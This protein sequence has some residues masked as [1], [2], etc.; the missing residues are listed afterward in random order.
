MS[1][2]NQI[3]N[4]LKEIDG[5]AF[6]KLSDTYILKK[7]YQ[8]INPIGSVLGADKV[9]TGTPDSYARQE[10]GKLIFAE[11]T[12]D[13]KDIYKKLRGDLEKC[14]DVKKTGIPLSEI[15]EVVFCHNSQLS[16]SGE[17]DLYNTCKA[18]GIKIQIF[19]LEG[20]SFDF[21]QKYPA[22]AHDFLGIDV[23]TG[24]ILEPKEFVENIGKNQISTPLDTEF[25]FREEETQKILESM[26]N[27]N[28]VILSGAAGVGK[29]RLALEVIDQF[30]SRHDDYGLW[31]VYNKGPD[32]FEDI[33]SYFSQ[34]GSFLLLVDDANRITQ[35]DYIVD[36]IQN[37]REDQ[38]IKVIATVRDYA[39]DK[40][41]HSAKALGNVSEFEIKP[42]TKDEIKEFIEKQYE[43]K[44]T[45][46]LDRISE[47]A[48]GNPRL[49]VMAAILAVQENTLESIRDVS[50]LYDSYFSS[51][52]NDLEHLQDKNILK[53]AGIISFFRIVDRSNDKV[54]QMIQNV[55]EISSSDFWKAVEYL[56]GAEIVDIY[57]NEVVKISDQVLS[58]YLFYLCFL[59]GNKT[60][61]S[62]LL[63][64]FFPSQIDRVRDAI[65]P[66]FNSFDFDR[67]AKKISPAVRKKWSECRDNAND[68]EL[69]G[70]IKTFWFLLQTDVLVY[71]R[72]NMGAMNEQCTDVDD[73]RFDSN[74]VTFSDHPLLEILGFFKQADEEGTF[75]SALALCFEYVRKRPNSAPQFINI[76]V[77]KFGFD[78][79]SH[80]NEYLLQKIVIQS[81]WEM[82]EGGS[83][84][85]FSKLFLEVASKYL[86]TRYDSHEASKREVTIHKFVLLEIEPINEI[87][88]IIWNGIFTIHKESSLRDHALSVLKNYCDSGYYLSQSEI[89]KT[90]AQY[91]VPFLNENLS[92]NDFSD[93]LLVQKY[94]KLLKGRNIDISHDV[95]DEF[96]SGSYELY[97]I[98]SFDYSDVE[99]DNIHDFDEIKKDRTKEYLKGFDFDK[100][101]EFVLLAREILSSLENNHDAYRIKSS[102][103][104][105][106]SYLDEVDESLYKEIMKDYITSGDPLDIQHP[107]IILNKLIKAFGSSSTKTLLDDAEFGTKARWLFDYYRCL[108]DGDIDEKVA[109]GLIELYKDSEIKDLPYDY[110]YLLRFVESRETVV[111][112]VV[113]IIVSKLDEASSGLSCFD[114]IFNPHSEVN[115]RILELFE[116]NFNLLKRVYLLHCKTKDHADYDGS[117]LRRILSVDQDFILEII[118]RIYTD[119]EWPDRYS[120]SRDYSF[121][122][123]H[124]NCE[125]I[126]MSATREVLKREVEK[127]YFSENYLERLF[128]IHDNKECPQEVVNKQDDFLGDV[129]SENSLD[130]DF[131]RFIF[132]VIS[133]FS[134]ERRRK[135]IALFLNKN[136]NY[137]DFEKLSFEPSHWS[138]SGSKVPM[139]QAKADFWGM[140]LPLCDSVE[141][142]D[143]KLF[144][145][146][147]IQSYREAVEREKKSNFMDEFD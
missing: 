103:P 3:Q 129:I 136:K 17:Q 10:N 118:D 84:E 105:V 66:C 13:Q 2:L 18:N 144:I 47:I 106:F 143:H 88:K 4:A 11:Y 44:N 7:G 131:M 134:A 34:S 130:S 23:D 67:M 68:N 24:Q 73:I 109:A 132:N 48:G 101:K 116:G 138:C 39:R 8:N 12:T 86:P 112:E 110:D 31:V 46:Y 1:K 43:I 79:H 97:K 114:L 36:L 108:P 62:L 42:L 115:K 53:V 35:F 20:I 51:I 74:N 63:D 135:F 120:D 32:L 100:Y 137:E 78:R 25:Y 41:N 102:I 71:V 14:F 94:N 45:V 72:D 40:V 104:L 95:S 147:N 22:L 90:D 76:M 125:K 54:M 80:R 133:N 16:L 82:T 119:N 139:Y 19:G 141:L 127:G 89:I 124:D 52:S 29:S 21:Y 27:E 87:R 107:A 26:D 6:Q 96:Y 142:L 93:C 56:H 61:F 113:E 59:K 64:N 85:L 65:Y 30:K 28:L 122:W 15:E 57:E 111:E 70:L 69:R 81:L 92:P 77:K 128:C 55:F 50:V 58:T 99:S 75:K 91:V 83:N 37:Q 146:K 33:R 123:G 117:T 126:M 98:L 60:G 9:R 5:G 49:A 145:E 38:N 140:L 121:L